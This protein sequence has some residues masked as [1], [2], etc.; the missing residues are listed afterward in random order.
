MNSL[1]PLAANPADATP[2]LGPRHRGGPF[3]LFVATFFSFSA[4]GGALLLWREGQHVWALAAATLLGSAALWACGCLIERWRTRVPLPRSHSVL[5][6]ALAF[7]LR[8]TC[9]DVGATMFF[10]PDRLA[11]GSATQ[12]LCF[13]ENYASR[14][15]VAHLRIGPHAGLGLPNA[16]NVALSLAAGQAA[17]YALP[18]TAAPT[19]AAG[20]HDLPLTLTVGKPSGTGARLPGT[21]R[22]LYDLWKI[23]VAAPFTLTANIAMPSSTAATILKVPNFV[24]L[25]SVGEAAP[26]LSALATFVGSAPAATS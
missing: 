22:H 17:V 6:G 25:A 9:R 13:V 5:A 10:D 1:T 8:C 15:R 23:H 18:L 16:F 19:L 14:R 7:D 26:R 4:A 21:P 24:S 2:D 11:P 3:A 12:L 20:E